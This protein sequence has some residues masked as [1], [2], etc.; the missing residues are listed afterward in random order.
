MRMLPVALA[1]VTVMA[2]PAHAETHKLGLVIGNNRGSDPARALRYAEQ[3]ARKMYAVLTELGGFD[4]SSLELLTGKDATAARQALG[5]LEQRAA[6]LGRDATTKTLLLIYY[7]GHADSDALEM[8]NTTFGFADLLEILRGSRADVRLAIIDSCQSGRLVK[9]KGGQ[10]GPAY[11]IHIEDEMASRGY[12]LVTSSAADELSQESTEVRGSLFSHFWISA[13]RGAAD[14][15]ADGRVTL[16]EAYAFAYARTLAR[17]S[18]TVGGGQHPMYDFR[19]SGSGRVVLTHPAGSESALVVTP[20]HSGRL[21]VIDEAAQT[22]VAEAPV[23]G[24]AAARFSVPAGRYRVMLLSQAGARSAAVDV[25]PGGLVQVG[26]AGFA[27]HA[28]R[29][30]VSKGGLFAP[31][32]THELAARG[33]VRHFPL[34][35]T[36]VAW[37]AALHH[38]V[39]WIESWNLA[40]RLAWAEAPDAGASTG[41]RE[42][43]LAAGGG[44]VRATGPVLLRLEAL[45]AYEHLF[46]NDLPGVT[47]HGSALALVGLMGVEIPVG[48]VKLGLEV[49][50]GGRLLRLRE[51]GWVLRE[52]W[53]IQ[54]GL[55]VELGGG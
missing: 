43:G 48:M 12:A 8:G 38:R 10:R 9:A 17:T 19:L 44:W 41:Y 5:R 40:A 52:D 18:A 42:L 36:P 54:A 2:V 32:V 27:P 3:D 11:A 4:A 53:Q 46:Q 30:E 29:A 24:S 47:R 20:D 31:T 25:P 21:V 28:L 45:A 22:V 7:S 55:G 37:G 49:G 1:L 6:E 33:L 14:A 23:D 34:K 16:A 39:Q 13:M 15:D 26:T 50:G 51:R 35:G